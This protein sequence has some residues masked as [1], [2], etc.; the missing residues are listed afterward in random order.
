MIRSTV[1]RRGQIFGR[2]RQAI[3]THQLSP[4]EVIIGTLHRVDDFRARIVS[5]D[6]S[7]DVILH[8]YVV[9]NCVYHQ[10]HTEL[11]FAYCHT[12][13]FRT[14]LHSVGTISLLWISCMNGSAILHAAGR[15]LMNLQFYFRRLYVSTNNKINECL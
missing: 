11:T 1:L 3:S 15:C 14:L 10:Y 9:D 7:A 4:D 6:A 8:R 13:S 12:D 2:L 5:E